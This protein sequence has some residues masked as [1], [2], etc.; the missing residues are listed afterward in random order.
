MK[1]LFPPA[2]FNF[3]GLTFGP[4]SI[5]APCRYRVSA[6]AGGNDFPGPMG[7]SVL[8]FSTHIVFT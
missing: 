1:M 4:L 5:C 7:K 6:P 8:T 2:T 3:P